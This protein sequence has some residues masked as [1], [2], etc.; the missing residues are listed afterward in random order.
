MSCGSILRECAKHESLARILLMAPE[1]F[2]LFQFVEL[3]NFD[4]SSDAFATFR[5]RFGVVWWTTGGLVVALV[6]LSMAL[7]EVGAKQ[8]CGC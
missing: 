6:V 2:N 3:P 5:V 4:V 7:R 1:F 8:G